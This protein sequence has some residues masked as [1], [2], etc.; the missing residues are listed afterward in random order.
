MCRETV[1]MGRGPLYAVLSPLI[2]KRSDRMIFDNMMAY[3]AYDQVINLELCHAFSKLIEKSSAV[4]DAATQHK[5]L[6]ERQ[7]WQMQKQ[8]QMSLS[9]QYGLHY[10]GQVGI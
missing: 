8:P 9:D 4:E 10:P 1:K 6:R 2:L 5:N 7:I 3:R